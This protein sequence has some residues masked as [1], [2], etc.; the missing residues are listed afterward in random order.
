MFTPEE[1]RK[2]SKSQKAQEI[3]KA[4]EAHETYR[5]HCDPCQ[6]YISSKQ[7]LGREETLQ[8]RCPQVALVTPEMKLW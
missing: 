8:R 2:A 3:Y 1:R 4:C 6:D 5:I 7:L